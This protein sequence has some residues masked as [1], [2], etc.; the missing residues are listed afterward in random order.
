MY[1]LCTP[2]IFE[3]SRSIDPERKDQDWILMDDIEAKLI[4]NNREWQTIDNPQFGK[5]I[6][7]VD[8]GNGEKSIIL[9]DRKR[10]IVRRATEEIPQRIPSP[11]ELLRADF[12]I[13]S[14]LAI[15]RTAIAE[16]G[17]KY[18]LTKELPA[19]LRDLLNRAKELGI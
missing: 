6:A 12:P 7:E 9:D 18:G 10:I 14:E 19:K 4:R 15:M 11:L 16:I 1:I 13:E 17:E 3:Q 2:E 8:R 5:Q